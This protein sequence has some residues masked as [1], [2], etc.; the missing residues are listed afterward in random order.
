MPIR[1][2]P[3]FKPPPDAPKRGKHR[4]RVTVGADLSTRLFLPGNGHLNNP[5]TGSLHRQKQ[6]NVKDK[7]PL[8][9][10]ACNHTIGAAWNN[11]GTTLRIYKSDTYQPPHQKAKD[12][13]GQITVKMTAGSIRVGRR[14]YR[15]RPTLLALPDSRSNQIDHG[16][17]ADSPIGIHKGQPIRTRKFIPRLI[18]GTSFARPLGHPEKLNPG[19]VG[20]VLPHQSSEPGMFLRRRT[21]IR[22]DQNDRQ[23]GFANSGDQLRSKSL[24]PLAVVPDRNNKNNFFRNLTHK[25]SL[26]LHPLTSRQRE[27][28]FLMVF[29]CIALRR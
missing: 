3:H 8:L 5:A 6:L 9:K 7:S 22:Y 16:T 19:K 18:N 21:I 4:P 2:M 26:R 28:I 23:A 24:Q 12:M 15:Y 25:R 17:A 13:E 27:N 11:L 29:S 14:A 10:L 20:L 1:V